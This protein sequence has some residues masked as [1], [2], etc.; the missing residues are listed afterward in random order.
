MSLPKQQPNASSI[1]IIIIPSIIIPTILRIT[2]AHKA[3]GPAAHQQGL[4]I[5]QVEDQAKGIAGIQVV[6]VQALAAQKA[7]LLVQ[8]CAGAVRLQ[9]ADDYAEQAAGR[10]VDGLFFLVVRCWIL[11]VGERK[12]MLEDE[13]LRTIQHRCA[14]VLRK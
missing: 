4:D 3:I 7:E 9:F 11:F 10:G 2:I 8:L 12:G 13:I 14:Q 6:A 5:L 1:Q